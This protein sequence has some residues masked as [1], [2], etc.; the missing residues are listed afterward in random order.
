MR[1]ILPILAA[2][3]VLALTGCQ[4]VMVERH[5]REPPPRD[6][7]VVVVREAPPPERHE[8]IGIAPSPEHVWIRGYWVRR[9]GGWEWA[10][11]HWERRPHPGAEWIAG[12]WSERGGEWHWQAGHWR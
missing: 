12:H 5:H 9:H 10:P 11:G 4:V 2:S 7:D 6:E 1:R 3:A 8:A